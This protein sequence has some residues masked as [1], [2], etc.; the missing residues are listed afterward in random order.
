[1]RI[2]LSVLAMAVLLATST[3]SAAQDKKEPPA[4]KKRL[5]VITESKGFVH[6][7]VNRKGQPLSL[8]EK[9]LTELG[10]KTGDWETVCSQDSRAA[11]T[12]E[13]LANFDAVFFYTT[14]EL[15]LSETQKSDLIQFV[16]SGK[17]FAGAHS[18]TDT[19]YKW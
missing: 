2:V 6:D 19:F 12:A 9:V 14:G 1:M 13:N 11:I 15:P 5:L 8:A 16:R 3:T 17:G 10:D 4:K 7:V 18:A